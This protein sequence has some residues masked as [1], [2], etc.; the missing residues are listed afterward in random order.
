MVTVRTTTSQVKIG[1]LKSTA[2][3]SSRLFNVATFPH[4]DLCKQRREIA[5]FKM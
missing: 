2:L 5:G 4:H 1:L 3:I